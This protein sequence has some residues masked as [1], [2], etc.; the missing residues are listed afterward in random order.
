[1]FDFEHLYS[2]REDLQFKVIR[3]T[4]FLVAG[5][6]VGSPAQVWALRV[7]YH[8]FK[9]RGRISIISVFLLLSDLLEMILIP[10]LLTCMF[11]EDHKRC[12]YI[13]TLLFE[14]RLCGHLLHQTVALES[15][16]QRYPSLANTFSLS[17]S[18]PLSIVVLLLAFG[19][20]FMHRIRYVFSFIA[21]VLPVFVCAVTYLLTWKAPYDDRQ[22]A[23]DRKLGA[24][25][26]TV[27]ILTLVILHMPFFLT[28]FTDLPFML[29]CLA[30]LRLISDPLL[31]VLVCSELA[32]DV[33]L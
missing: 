23:T 22:Q 25:V 24:L 19:G 10:F 12:D 30:S 29:D 32:S 8:H 26:V 1:M 28:V 14:A 9:S 20:Q 33:Q 17:C 21:C 15:V 6:A 18:L 27:A 4:I 16:S 7:L 13:F 2:V 3:L 5:V 31:C 11:Q